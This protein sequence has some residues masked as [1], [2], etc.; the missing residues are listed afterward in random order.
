[1]CFCCVGSCW[2]RL[3][4]C[5]V[6][7]EREDVAAVADGDSES[8]RRVDEHPFVAA[9]VERVPLL[10]EFDLRQEGVLQLLAIH[11]PW[12]KQHLAVAN[13]D[14]PVTAQ[15]CEC[16]LAECTADG[17]RHLQRTQVGDE[18]AAGSEVHRCAGIH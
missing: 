14:V 3:L 9:E 7:H 5:R 8:L 12:H 10:V 15:R 6:E 4:V 17:N 16:D 13:R 1:M 11:H 18:I 2:C